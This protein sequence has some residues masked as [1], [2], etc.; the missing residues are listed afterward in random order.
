MPL[1]VPI[2][3]SL[4][5]D[6]QRNNTSLL[7]AFIKEKRGESELR[8]IEEGQIYAPEPLKEDV[9]DWHHANLKYPGDN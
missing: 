7:G 3:L 5:E 9:I 2:K 4:I 1:K 6:H 8:V